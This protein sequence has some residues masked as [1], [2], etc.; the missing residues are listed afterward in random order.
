MLRKKGK[1]ALIALGAAL[2]WTVLYLIMPLPFYSLFFMST[3]GNNLLLAAMA[4]IL[5]LC[6]DYIFS[7][8]L[9]AEIITAAHLIT[10]IVFMVGFIHLYSI[11]RYTAVYWVI[12]SVVGYCGAEAV[13]FIKARREKIPL[14]K[15]K[16]GG[17][18]ISS[19]VMGAV[20]A[21]LSDCIYLLLFTILLNSFAADEYGVMS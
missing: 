9:K 20:C 5:T 2:L 7:R 6:T 11:F 12:I 21:L 3:V 1:A 18:K 10:G 15:E 8:A 17:G 13:I 16:K 19:A 14:I 4:A